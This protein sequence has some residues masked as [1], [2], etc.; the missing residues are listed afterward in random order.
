M[1]FLIFFWG[2]RVDAGSE[3]TYAE[4]NRVPPP[5]GLNILDRN[6]F[7]IKTASKNHSKSNTYMYFKLVMPLVLCILKHVR[8]LI[9]SDIKSDRILKS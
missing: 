5:W 7:D 6:I 1:I 2:G 9:N 4:K 3:P 8:Q